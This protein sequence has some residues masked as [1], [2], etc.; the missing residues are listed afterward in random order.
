MLPTSSIL[1]DDL[2]DSADLP[3]E[4]LAAFLEVARQAEEVLAADPAN[5]GLRLVTAPLS[6]V[7]A[8]P[9]SPEDRTCDLCRAYVPAGT[10]LD[11]WHAIV[12]RVVVY[13]GFCPDCALAFRPEAAR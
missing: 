8:E 6:G 2:G 3:P 5:A 4:L 13:A 9:G 11:V 12:G 1:G 7:P 10:G